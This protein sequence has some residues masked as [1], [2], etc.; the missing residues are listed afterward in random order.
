M[1]QQYFAQSDLLMWPLVGLMLFLM[2]FMGVLW[3]VFNGLGDAR[4]RD[5]IAALPLDDEQGGSA[6]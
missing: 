4:V 6:E 3:S 5:H 1:F 2:S